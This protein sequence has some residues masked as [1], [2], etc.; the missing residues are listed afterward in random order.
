MSLRDE[1]HPHPYNVNWV[2]KT[3]HCITQRSQVPVHMFSYEDYVWCDVLDIDATHILL[4]RLWLYD[5]YV[6]SLGK[7]N[8]YEFKF[9]EKIVLKLAKPKSGVGNNKEKTITEKN[10]KTS[11]YLVTKIH[12]SPY[13][14]SLLLMGLHLGLGIFAAFSLFP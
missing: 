5:L 10:D 14:L 2:D 11:C 7:F 3:T 8:T 9:T 4:G 1:P 6:T 13:S 12:F